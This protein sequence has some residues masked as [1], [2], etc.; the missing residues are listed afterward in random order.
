[1]KESGVKKRNEKEIFEEIKLKM[2]DLK[3][4]ASDVWSNQKGLDITQYSN[5]ID[6]AFGKIMLPLKEEIK[7]IDSSVVKELYQK[8]KALLQEK[9]HD[10]LLVHAYNITQ[11]LFYD[12]LFDEAFSHNR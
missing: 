12:Y 7:G 1:M 10:Y 4:A 2:D 9:E 5:D 8:T 11:D 3:K 6:E